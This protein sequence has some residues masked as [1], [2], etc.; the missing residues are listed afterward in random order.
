MQ[1]NQRNDIELTVFD[2]GKSAGPIRNEKMAEYSDNLVIFWGGKSI[3]S[4][5]M[6]RLAKKHDLKIWEIKH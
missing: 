1:T 3:G 2:N 6:I 4:K 5:S